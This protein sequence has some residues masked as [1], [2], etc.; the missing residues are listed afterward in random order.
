MKKDRKIHGAIISYK[1][2]FVEFSESENSFERFHY[3]H[4]DTLFRRLRIVSPGN[5]GETP[6]PDN[7]GSL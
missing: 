1:S 3:S 6:S 5:P 7:F 4:D 2:Q